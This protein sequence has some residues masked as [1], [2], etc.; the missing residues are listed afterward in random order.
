MDIA[1]EMTDLNQKRLESGKKEKIAIG[2]G[3]SSG[4][5]IAGNVDSGDR[6]EY[7]VIGDAANMVARLED[8]AGDNQILISPATYAKVQ[9]HVQ[10]TPWHRK[11]SEASRN[12]LPSMN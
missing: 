5:V 11:R 10:A 4:E 2:M 6:V 7:T 9:D 3:V 1:N 12:E 8:L